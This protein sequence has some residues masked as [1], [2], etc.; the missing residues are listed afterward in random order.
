M[1][2]A[3]RPGRR[4]CVIRALARFHRDSDGAT[5]VELGIL[6]VP[7][8]AL[9]FAVIEAGMLFFSSQILETAVGDAGRNI[10]TG[11][12]QQRP[13]TA[14]KTPAQLIADFKSDVC[15]PILQLFSCTTNLKVDV[16]SYT[17]FPSSIPSPIITDASGNRQVDPTFGQYQTIAPDGVVVIRALITYPVFVSLL[18]SNPSN[19]NA[20]TRVLM[21]TT[22]FQAEPY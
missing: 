1:T 4:R 8:L 12:F 15:A 9:I 13:G 17:T 3:A 14:A 21:A 5:A 16:K 22:A 19:L 2:R 6:A 7:L 18:G 10:Y 20:R 11:S